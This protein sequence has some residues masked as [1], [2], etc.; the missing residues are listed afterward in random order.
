MAH[1][2]R[3][4]EVSSENSQGKPVEI[5]TNKIDL[6]KHLQ[7]W[8]EADISILGHDLL[9]VGREVPTAFGGKI[10]LLCLDSSG[11]LVVVELK[12]GRTPREVAAQVLDY[13]CWVRDL[14]YDA[15]V[16]LFKDYDSSTIS[17]KE[18]FDQKYGEER[19]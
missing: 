1:Q 17:L 19:V 2:I 11:G 12:K 18:A 8:L 9:V 3:M 10:D 13:A 4:W 16:A 14:S 15:I 5:S 6:E 7:K